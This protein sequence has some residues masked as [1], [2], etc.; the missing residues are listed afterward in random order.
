M[1]DQFI[2]ADD[3]M[4]ALSNPKRGLLHG[5][6]NPKILSGACKDIYKQLK[7]AR[8]FVVEP[9]LVRYVAEMACHVTAKELLRIIT[10]V[11]RPAHPNM[12]LEWDEFERVRITTNIIA[13]IADEPHKS[14]CQEMIGKHDGVV[15]WGAAPYAGYLIQQRDEEDGCIA[16][17]T[18]IY[19]NT[20]YDRLTSKADDRS[21]QHFTGYIG[22]DPEVAR[23][24]ANKIT[25]SP[26]DW[27]VD[28]SGRSFSDMTTYDRPTDL[29]LIKDNPQ[30]LVD[31]REFWP[32]QNRMSVKSVHRSNYWEG[33]EQIIM[34]VNEW[35]SGNSYRD[36]AV[37]V[38]TLV[39]LL[40]D[41]WVD[42][43]SRSDILDLAFALQWLEPNISGAFFDQE[44]LTDLKSSWGINVTGDVRFVMCLLSV[45]N[46]NWTIETEDMRDTKRRIRFGKP[47]I[48]NS[49]RVVELKLPKPFGVTHAI[50]E[51]GIDAPTVRRLHDV[52]GHWVHR[53]KSGKRYWRKAHKR[54]DK[55]LG[56]IIKDYDLSGGHGMTRASQSATPVGHDD[57]QD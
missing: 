43:Q 51:M 41:W 52:M 49:Y 1:T 46:Y 54:G 4:A 45:L 2:L 29:D 39:T 37:Y 42:K 10:D 24:F 5:R 53:K 38:D 12:W 56:E 15:P 21:S 26:Y 33:R 34:A 40:G 7:E 47:V 18:S 3:L 48:G 55:R 13:E 31:H 30:R 22:D 11:A 28:H 20:T 32:H 17:Y 19:K 9:E 14:V 8:R 25:I 35:S 27:W 44:V 23:M 16:T 6:K 50:K 36:N 57:E